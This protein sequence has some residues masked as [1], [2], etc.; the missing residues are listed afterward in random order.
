MNY[1]ET[2]ELLTNYLLARI[3]L[4]GINTI[5]KGRAIELLQEISK[6]T[7]M[8]MKVHSMSKGF[9]N[10]TTGDVY[11]NDKLMMGAL[12]YIVEELKTSE[13]Q[14]YILSDVSE[15]DSETF[16][17]RYLVDIT[18][19]AEQKSS[20]IIIITD[21]PIWVQLQRQGMIIDLQ[22]PT[23]E[24]LFNII[25]EN[26]RPYQNQIKIEWNVNDVKE[27]AN[28]LQGISKIEV[29]NVIASLIAKGS[30]LKDDLIDLKFAKD[31]LF[32]NINGLEKIIVE[33]NI[34][35]GGLEGLKKWLDEK[36]KLLNPEKREKM[37][38]RG[39][40]PPRGILL[41]GVPGCGK[42]LSA[43][44]IA[45][46]WKRPLYRLDFATIQ[47]RYVGQSEQQLKSALETAEHV[48]PCILWIDEIEKG[49]SGGGTDSSGVTTRLI[50][51]FLFWL[52]ECNKDVF[53]VAT[54]NDVK[55]LPPEL[56]RKGRFDEM[57]FIDLPNRDER[58]SI[59]NIYLNKYLD[60]TADER[61]VNKLVN[62]SE[63]F[64]GSD[65]ESIIRD[66]AYNNI[67]DVID[68]N[69]ETIEDAFRKSISM[70]KTNKEKI[71]SIRQ[72]AKDRT[73][74]ASIID[75]PNSLNNNNQHTQNNVTENTIFQ[76][77]T[78]QNNTTS[79]NDNRP[80]P[81]TTLPNNIDNLDLI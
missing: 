47:G 81:S 22:L 62:I 23:E 76:S 37:K 7:N 77:S 57:F 20:S 43:K 14:I 59:I 42:S 66:V 44:A 32:S 50:G 52:Q 36:E 15:L 61:Y 64:S 49:L 40:R 12:D 35:Y 70:Y 80:N 79:Q 27:A 38:E 74:H 28:I 46:R 72:W 17:S 24:E 48:S 4:I 33:E 56:L 53:V 16:V 41:M 73:I 10:L 34:A 65:I 31:S 60:V 67:A 11:N 1:N 68:I 78:P 55:E 13:N 30:I 29:K 39:I 71:E 2:K 21:A 45:S 26:I 63:N 9:T 58:K 54:A 19:L 5:E 18:N 6:E 8:N 75:Q 69:E 3:P 51:Q 25:V